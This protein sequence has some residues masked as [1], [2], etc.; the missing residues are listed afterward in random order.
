VLLETKHYSASFCG[1]LFWE[2]NNSSISSIRV[3][4]LHQIGWNY[5]CNKTRR[6]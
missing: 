1:W 4:S 5:H 6:E 3:G 2:P